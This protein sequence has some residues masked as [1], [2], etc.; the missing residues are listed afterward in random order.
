MI[1]YREWRRRREPEETTGGVRTTGGGRGSLVWERCNTG[2]IRR[3]G[4]CNSGR[5]GGCGD[6]AKGKEGAKSRR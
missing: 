3:E 4:S 5:S 6:K 1:E 2:F